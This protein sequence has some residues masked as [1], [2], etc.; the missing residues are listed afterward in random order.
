VTAE[1]FLSERSDLVAARGCVSRS[2]A[3]N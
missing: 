2:S 3:R 1:N